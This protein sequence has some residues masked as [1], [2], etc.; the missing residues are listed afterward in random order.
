MLDAGA[1]EGSQAK[2]SPAT[3]LLVE[4]ETLTRLMLVDELQSHGH[5]V[6]L[7]R[8]MRIRLW[9]SCSPTRRLH[10]C[11]PTSRCREPLTVLNL[12]ALP[13]LISPS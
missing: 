3:I 13:A 6:V 11:S 8:R 9:R 10:C 1:T 4:D 7:K 12:R 2:Q 5:D